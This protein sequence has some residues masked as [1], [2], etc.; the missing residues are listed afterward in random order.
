MLA[1]QVGQ[2][3][4]KVVE[5]HRH[6]AAHGVSQRGRRATV[7]DAVHLAADDLQEPDHA[8]VV[9]T[10]RAGV[11]IA[12]LV[13]IGAHVRHE[14]GQ[15]LRGELR[16]HAQD[17]G[18]GDQV[19]DGREILHRVVRQVGEQV[20]RGAMRADG[21]QAHGVAVRLGARH[22]RGADVAARPRAVLHHDALADDGAQFLRDQPAQDV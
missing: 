20:R 7:R 8:Q 19:A 3:R 15:R 11:G 4:R 5:D 12:V 18:T 17:V 1:F 2:R 6:H 22:L 10:A 16:I 9:H 13:R 21:G 14:V